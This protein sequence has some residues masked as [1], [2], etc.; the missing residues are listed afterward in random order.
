MNFIESGKYIE[1]G[2]EYRLEVKNLYE[3]VRKLLEKQQ[4]IIYENYFRK[5]TAKVICK[6]MNMKQ[7]TLY[8]TGNKAFKNFRKMNRYYGY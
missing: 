6:Q 8:N 3:K 2:F 5:K 1:Q 4:K 7:S